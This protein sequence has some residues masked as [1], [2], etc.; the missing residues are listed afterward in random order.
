MTMFLNTLKYTFVI[1][2]NLKF[3][4]KVFC[5]ALNQKTYFDVLTKAHVKYLIIIVTVTYY[6]ILQLNYGIWYYT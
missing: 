2:S 3:Y 1:L 5:C 4:F 6:L